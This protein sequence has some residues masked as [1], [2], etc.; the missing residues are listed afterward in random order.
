MLAL[1]KG[2]LNKADFKV[3]LRRRKSSAKRGSSHFDKRSIIII[4][5]VY[6]PKQLLVS[7]QQNKS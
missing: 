7:K 1:A 3:D 2:K 5:N 6:E 4:L